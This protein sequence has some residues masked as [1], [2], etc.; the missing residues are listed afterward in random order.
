MTEPIES[1]YFNWLCAKVMQIETPTPSLTFW[2]LLRELHNTEFVWLVPNDDNRGADGIDLRPEFLREAS[3]DEDLL[4]NG[5][6]CSIFEMLYAFARRAEFE[7]DQPA[8][9]WFWIFIDNLELSEFNDVIFNKGAIKDILSS[10]VWRTY[11]YDGKK[12]G[13]F[14]IHFPDRDQRKVE[15]W[16]Q[17]C[18]YLIDLQ[19]R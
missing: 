11:E 3:L 18:D 5:L 7:T 13:L 16:Y 8:K 17:F 9:E 14:P 6:A 1:L 15:V 4:F 2:K 19:R 10:F 12:G